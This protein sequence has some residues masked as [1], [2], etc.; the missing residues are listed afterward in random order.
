M[1]Q[2]GSSARERLNAP[3]AEAESWT[4]G[5]HI[6]LWLPGVAMMSI[7]DLKMGMESNSKIPVIAKEP[8]IKP[9]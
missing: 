1:G 3:A 4:F 9:E 7:L 2:K 6:L 5:C 8:E